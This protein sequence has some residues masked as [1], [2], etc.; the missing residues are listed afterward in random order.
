MIATGYTH[1]QVVST[2]VAVVGC[3][4]KISASTITVVDIFKIYL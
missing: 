4:N 3:E 1:V 2:I